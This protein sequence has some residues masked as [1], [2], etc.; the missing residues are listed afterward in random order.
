MPTAAR[1]SGGQPY[2]P[3][4]PAEAAARGIV[5]VH[6]ST[7][8]LGT[9]GLSVADTLLLDSYADGSASFFLNR[10]SV[11]RKARADIA[12]CGL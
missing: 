12:G 4:A 7:D 10:S 9:P 5:T 1:L 8:K 6:Q 11:R 3:R 2:A